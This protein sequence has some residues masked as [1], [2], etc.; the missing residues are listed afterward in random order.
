MRGGLIGLGGGLFVDLHRHLAIGAHLEQRILLVAEILLDLV[1][2][3]ALVAVGQLVRLDEHLG[4]VDRDVVL[5]HVRCGQRH[6]LGDGHVGAV[7]NLEELHL[8]LHALGHDDQ[9]FPFPMADRIA[10]IGRRQVIRPRHRLVEE[11]AARL[12][13]ELR[14]YRHL[15]GRLEELQREDRAHHRWH[16]LWQAQSAGIGER[17]A[18]L[19]IGVALGARGF[20]LRGIGLAQLRA[21]IGHRQL[22]K[23]V[24]VAGER[25]GID[26]P[27]AGDVGAFDLHGRLRHRGRDRRRNQGK[28]QQRGRCRC[29]AILSGNMV[30]LLTRR[31]RSGRRAASPSSACRRAGRCAAGN[32]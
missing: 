24:L 25:V 29:H 31:S 20:P 27:H 22:D 17:G 6:P 28:R 32:R 10:V 2:V 30:S 12:G 9:R 13:Q 19:Q 1:A 16:T 8:F 5:D 18:R 23:G 11:D 21:A 3:V 7:W 26:F 15:A 14:Q 4:I